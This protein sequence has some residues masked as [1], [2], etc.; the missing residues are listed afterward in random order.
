MELSVIIPVLDE[1]AGIDACLRRL[2]AQPQIAEVI[3]VDGNSSDDTVA[4]ARSYPGVTVI[5]GERGRGRQLNAG[6]RAARGDT[7]LFLHAD[8]ELPAQAAA[9]IAAALDQRGVVAGAFRTWHV[10]ERW[11]GKRRAP[12]LH[13]ADLRSR[14]SSLPYGDQA[15]FLRAQTFDRVGGYPQLAL[16]EDLAMSRALR[17]LGRIAIVPRSVRV[18]GR[19]FESA[20]FRQT[21]LVNIFP[22]LYAAGVSPGTLARFYGNPR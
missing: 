16:M 17:R 7:L 3:V 15:L 20:L 18:S 11:A 21:A 2:Q 9:S 6:A 22:L 12:L 4:R 19:R 1:A 10:P 5:A 14:Y 13:L 8:A